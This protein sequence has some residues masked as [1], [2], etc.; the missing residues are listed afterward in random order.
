MEALI[1]GYLNN[2]FAMH[3]KKRVADVLAISNPF[4]CLGPQL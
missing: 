4:A 1:I 2:L 3:E